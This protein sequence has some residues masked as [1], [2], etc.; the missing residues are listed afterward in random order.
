VPRH[1][2]PHDGGMN[3]TSVSETPGAARAAVL[4]VALQPVTGP[5]SVIRSLAAEQRRTGLYAG[6]GVGVIAYRDWPAEYRD[7]LAKFGELGFIAATPALFGTGSFLWQIWFKP[8][9]REWVQAL[10]VRTNAREVVV[11]VH[12]AWLSGALLPIVVD[13]VTVTVLATFHGV[14]GAAALRRQPA[15]RLIHRW[16]AQ[17]LLTFGAALTSVDEVNLGQVKELFGLA[18]ARFAIVP[19]GMPA[20]T[21]VARHEPRRPGELVVLHAGTLNQGKGWRIAAEAVLSLKREGNNVRLLIAGAGPDQAAVEALARANPDCIEYLGYVRDPVQG[22]FPKSDVFILMTDNDGLP[23][24]IIEALSCAVPVIS[25]RVGGIPG[26]VIDG[27]SGLL[28]ERTPA[29]L[30]Q[31]LREL[32]HAPGRL[33]ALSQGALDTFQQR[34]DVR[35]VAE[36]YDA[37]YRCRPAAAAPDAHTT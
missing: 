11:H 3:R 20:A 19:N 12:N 10:A 21:G 27:R 23:M 24:A 17:R 37:I 2:E 28:V 15:R 16:I 4:H 34:F 32:H 26:A 8:P 7:D 5:W 33:A 31:A 35:H 22:L 36:M 25:T 13:G 9:L 1:I 14:A 6:V 29:A 18:P 30:A